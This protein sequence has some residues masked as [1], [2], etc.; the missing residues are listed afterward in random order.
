METHPT[1]DVQNAAEGTT[2]PQVDAE[3]IFTFANRAPEILS[4]IH[5]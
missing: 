4:L 3:L 1:T 5:I 2:A